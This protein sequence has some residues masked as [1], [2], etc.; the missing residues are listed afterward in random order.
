[1]LKGCE[2]K[3]SLLMSFKFYSEI[4]NVTDILCVY[5][6]SGNSCSKLLK[7]YNILPVFVASCKM[8]FIYQ[9]TESG[10]VSFQKALTSNFSGSYERRNYDGVQISLFIAA[11]N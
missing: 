1:M 10:K 5:K 2:P 9:G 6:G 8:L 7:C 11:E 4:S 3:L